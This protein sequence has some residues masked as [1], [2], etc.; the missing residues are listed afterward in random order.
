[1]AG[2]GDIYETLL[3]NVCDIRFTRRHPKRGSAET[4]RMW[5]TNC[6]PLL[7]SFNGLHVLNY[8]IPKDVP[9]YNP[10]DLLTII[11]WDILMQDFRTISTESC[12]IIKSVPANKEFWTFFNKNILVMS[13]A[14]KINFMN[15]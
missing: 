2:Y 7:E 11:T 14:D 12:N 1:M 5:C 4:R 15:T 6:K 8:R 10:R 3:H 9:R 13:T